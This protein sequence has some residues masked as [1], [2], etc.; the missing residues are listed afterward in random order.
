VGRIVYTRRVEVE[1]RFAVHLAARMLA[2][3]TLGY[4]LADSPASH[5]RGGHFIPW[6]IPEQWTADLVRTF[7]PYVTS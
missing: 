4:G 3:S 1:R 2:P 5:P 7:R 6:E